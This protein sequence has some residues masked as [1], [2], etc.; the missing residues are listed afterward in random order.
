MTTMFLT[1]GTTWTVPNDWNNSSNTIE[2]IGAG[3]GGAGGHLA[4]GNP[5]AGGGGGAYATISNVALTP[6]ASIAIQIGQGGIGGTAENGGT[7][8]KA[9]KFNTT[10]TTTFIDDY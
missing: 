3:G 2:A 4:S 1:S 5:G 8:G 6:G 10:T 7:D 9:S